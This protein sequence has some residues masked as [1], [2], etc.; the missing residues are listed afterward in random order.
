M[1]SV[2]WARAATSRLFSSA[3]CCSSIGFPSA[4][5]GPQ[6]YGHA[7]LGGSEERFE[8]AYAA[9]LRGVFPDSFPLEAIIQSVTDDTLTP[10]GQHA[11]ILGV[12]NLP[13]DLA[14]G[15][16]DSRKEEFQEREE[17]NRT[18][19]DGESNRAPVA[20]VPIRQTDRGA[21]QHDAD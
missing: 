5:A 12:Q 2:V 16:W 3:I 18:S 21:D 14:E 7:I 17:A 11:M 20:G 10:K 15:D 1:A 4:E 19:T 6:H 8:D 9:M 13:F